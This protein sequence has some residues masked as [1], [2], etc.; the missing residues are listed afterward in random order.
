MSVIFRI[1]KSKD[2]EEAKSLGF[3]T[4]EL[5]RDG[6]IHLSEYHQVIA[7]A[8]HI[9]KGQKG[10][11]LLAVDTEKLVVQ[12]RYEKLG[13]VELF[14]HVYGVINIDA[15]IAVAEFSPNAHGLFELPEMG[16]S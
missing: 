6:F 13:T 8:N 15:V 2:W 3:Y 5:N 4:G 7:V 9:Y 10:L 16:S 11:L 12:V 14:P 1:S